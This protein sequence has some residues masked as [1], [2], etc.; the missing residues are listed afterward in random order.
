M[1]DDIGENREEKSAAST[2]A[3]T[4]EPERG[5]AAAASTAGPNASATANAPAAVPARATTSPG[6]FRRFIWLQ[7]RVAE[8]RRTTFGPS[9]PGFAEYDAARHAKE[10]VVQIGE[11]GQTSWSVLLLER[12]A[13]SLLLRA[14]AAKNGTPLSKGALTDTDW[15]NA[16]KVPAVNE[17]WNNLSALQV[18][19]L[20]DALSEGGEQATAQLPE[21]QR[22][23]FAVGLHSF[24]KTL[25]EPLE[26]EANR[27]GRALFARYTR[28]AVLAVAVLVIIVG[29][30]NWLG[31]RFEKPNIALHRPVET[32]SQYPGAGEDHSLLVDG[33]RTNLGFHTNCEGP[34]FVVVDLGA[35]RQIDKVVVYNR[36]E[37]QERAVPIFLDVS[38][39]KQNFKQVATRKEVFDKWAAT[40]LGVQ[41]RYVRLRHTPPNCFHLSEVEV[42]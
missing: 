40:G 30:S 16:R 39:D 42:Y 22:K 13:A 33:D 38:T 12:M 29:I 4:S 20:V 11:T 8:A 36:P 2:G 27:L 3:A 7:E 10:G 34:Q 31:S 25:S 9:Q 19:A 5:V 6:V 28:V 23:A 41:A 37:F 24:V 14:H 1:N 26:F 15:E 18:S 35:V 32:S 17:A 21:A